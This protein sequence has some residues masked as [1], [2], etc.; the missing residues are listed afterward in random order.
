M[1]SR[2]DVVAECKSCG[3][4][5]PHSQNGPCAT[6]GATGRLSKKPLAS[7]LS[8]NG[9]NL[10][11][12][13][14]GDPNNPEGRRVET[15]PSSGGRSISATEI[16]GSFALNLSKGLEVGRAGENNA[17]G[18]LI[19][20]LTLQG[21]DVRRLPGAQDGR[22]E[23][24]LLMIDGKQRVVQFVTV[25]MDQALWQT[26]NRSNASDL[27]GTKSDAV[28]LVRKAFVLKKTKAMGTVLV[29]DAAHAGALAYPGL[30]EK[31]QE[32]YGDPVKE[33]ALQQAWIVGP[34]ARSAFQFGCGSSQP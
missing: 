3:A 27:R 28:D 30:V 2:D 14:E 32:I 7:E 10:G 23:D 22:G 11:I 24:A 13:A 16:D 33:F 21:H 20:A 18:V 5:Y 29:L 19:E 6:C 8:F 31:Y 26:L 9:N 1:T 25:P 4:P 17:L 34:T 12:A 15:R